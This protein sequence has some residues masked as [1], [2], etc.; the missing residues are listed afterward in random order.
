MLCVTC[1]ASACPVIS[2]FFV[3]YFAKK[4]VYFPPLFQSF[5]F[6]VYRVLCKQFGIQCVCYV[7]NVCIF[8]SFHSFHC[9][10]LVFC[11]FCLLQQTYLSQSNSSNNQKKKMLCFCR[12]MIS[13][14][15]HRI[16]SLLLSI[17]PALVSAV[18]FSHLQPKTL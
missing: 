5:C 17:L 3:I 16:F 1:I 9:F 11:D 15:Y 6:A 18:S 10:V 4:I 14:H 7:L 8:N 13:I 12:L 2:P